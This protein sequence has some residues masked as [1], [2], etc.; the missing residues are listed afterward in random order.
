MFI[1]Y[2]SQVVGI[3]SAGNALVVNTMVNAV[4]PTAALPTTTTL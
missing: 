3:Y 2:H 1:Q 4:L